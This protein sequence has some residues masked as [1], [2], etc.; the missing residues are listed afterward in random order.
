MTRLEQLRTAPAAELRA[1][2]PPESQEDLVREW[3]LLMHLRVRALESAAL[4]QARR[5]RPALESDAA[6]DHAVELAIGAGRFTWR[7]SP[8][9]DQALA[10]LRRQIRCS[11]KQLR[12][13]LERLMQAG[14]VKQEQLSKG[15]GSVLFV[16][17]RG[18]P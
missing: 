13:S 15:D 16:W 14:R 9:T 6:L 7:D 3:K 5:S 1:L 18:A 8:Y 11:F 2:Q 10:H 17:K 12:E 4:A